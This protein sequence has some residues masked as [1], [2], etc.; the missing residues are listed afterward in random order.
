MTIT[1]D[2]TNF[3]HHKQYTEVLI[4]A[5]TEYGNISE[6]QEVEL[7]GRFAKCFTYTKI[8]T[9]SGALTESYKAIS[10]RHSKKRTPTQPSLNGLL[11]VTQV[12][13]KKWETDTYM[14][15]CRP[16]VMEILHYRPTH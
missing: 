1:V 15:L 10:S 13:M 12:I 16:W 11:T 6:E 5:K 4:E 8:L 7:L 2:Q 9:R 3:E 14:T